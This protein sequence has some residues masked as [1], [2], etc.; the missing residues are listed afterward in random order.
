[1]FEL[2]TVLLV[3]FILISGFLSATETALFS[4]P[5]SRVQVYKKSHDPALRQ[6]HELLTKPKDLLV[7]ILMFNILCNL[8]VQNVVSS[9]FGNVSSW[10]W[11][12]GFPLVLTLIFGEVIPKA[13][14][15]PNNKTLARRIAPLMYQLQKLTSPIRSIIIGVTS[16][17]SR[18]VFFFLKK[19]EDISKE[20]LEHVLATSK[21]FGI[22]KEDEAELVL[23]YLQ[24]KNSSAK[25]LM[26]P[27]EDIL[28][29]NIQDPLNKLAYLF[30]EQECTRIPVCDGS[31][32]NILGIMSAGQ[33][34]LHKNYIKEGEQI[35]SYLRKAFFVPESTPSAILL[36]QMERQVQNFAIVV[37][38]YGAISGILTKEDLVE[39]VIGEI[40]DRRDTK[41]LYTQNSLDSIICSGKLELVEFEKIFQKNLMTEN[42]MITI[43][44]WI[45]EHLGDIPKAGT[46]FKA[47]GFLF[48]ILSAEPHKIK[49]I[50]IKKLPPQPLK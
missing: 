37:D 15:L 10:L 8:M 21:E 23:G 42:N 3:V 11:R 30:V 38:E 31:L 33:F 44:G 7:T 6:I 45:C 41:P 9:L 13:L 49:R 26:K 27:R 43:G 25:E 32:E 40:K 1:M 48:Q 35:K 34:F 17:V 47:K 16:I 14:A 12:V 4:L 50:F 22:L 24:L 29:Y 2:L 28:F 20:E 46:K 5:M 19:E 39:V 36:Q 18:F